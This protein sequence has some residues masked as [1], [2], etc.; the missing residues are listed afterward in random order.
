METEAHIPAKSHASF[1][2]YGLQ[3]EFGC[4][5]SMH[6]LFQRQLAD[7]I[8]GLAPRGAFLFPNSH[9]EMSYIGRFQKQLKALQDANPENTI[10]EAFSFCFVEGGGYMILGGY[11]SDNDISPMCFTPFSSLNRYY[12]VAFST[13]FFDDQRAYYQI[14]KW[15]ANGGVMIDSG[16]TFTYLISSEYRLLTQAF[17]EALKLSLQ[18]AHVQF[19]PVK[20]FRVKI[21][22]TYVIHRNI[23][24]TVWIAQN[25]FH[26]SPHCALRF[27]RVVPL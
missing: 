15:N 6:G 26:F 2:R 13:V 19:P 23:T 17:T 25:M 7:G 3:Q 1:S 27:L 21:L 5:H 8:I 10:Q 24:V 18:K 9:L 20:R 11:D 14:N 22:Q 16:T 12:R 4:S